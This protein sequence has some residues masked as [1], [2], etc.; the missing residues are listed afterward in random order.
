MKL[1][2]VCSTLS[3]AISLCV[4]GHAFSGTTTTQDFSK[5][6]NPMIG[7]DSHGNFSH[8]NKLPYV[9]TP[10]PM[11]LLSP[12]MNTGSWYYAYSSCTKQEPNCVDDTIVNPITGFRFSHEPSPWIGDYGYFSLMPIPASSKVGEDTYPSND[13]VAAYGSFEHANEFSHPYEYQI[14]FAN[15]LKSQM[16]SSRRAG[17]LRFTMPDPGQKIRLIFDLQDAG[18]Q[19]QDQISWPSNLSDFFGY[20]QDGN[21]EGLPSDFKA[22]FNM[23]FYQ[24]D[25]TREIHPTEIKVWDSGT[26]VEP[27]FNSKDQSY[28]ATGNHL[29]VAFTFDT[30][31]VSALVGNSYISSSQAKFNLEHEMGKTEGDSWQP[32]RF[33]DQVALSKADWNRYLSRVQLESP[34]V[35]QA[36]FDQERAVYYTGLYRTLI[37]PHAWFECSQY[38]ANGQCDTSASKNAD[39]SYTYNYLFHRSPYQAYQDD[40]AGQPLVHNGYIFTDEGTWDVYRTKYPFYSLVFPD[41]ENKLIQGQLNVYREGGWL[42]QWSSPGYRNSMTGTHS[43]CVIADAYLR[44][45]RDYD[46]STAFA[47][48]LKDAQQDPAGDAQCANGSKCG[49]TDFET[50]QAHGYIP[51]SSSGSE[52]TG[53][54]L[55]YAYDDVCIANMADGLIRE[56]HGLAKN[57]YRQLA[58]QMRDESSRITG[59]LFDADNPYKVTDP[60]G[61]T[62]TLRGFFHTREGSSQDG[63]PIWYGLTTSNPNLSGL[64]VW[65][66]GYNE[67]SAWQF[68]FYMPYDVPKLA[69]LFA[70]ANGISDP[71]AAL[72]AQL[73][74][75]FTSTSDYDAT[76]YGYIHEAKEMTYLG[77]GQYGFND[78]PSWGNEYQYNYTHAPGKP[79]ALSGI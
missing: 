62:D 4:S 58:K 42:S 8:G 29:I 72:E 21:Q 61:S 11:T 38:T 73:D 39:G 20:T 56:S 79:S 1:K 77:L 31:E 50:L 68:M 48:I 60:D 23:R 35:S 57:S 19:R 49:R 78:Q 34:N 12:Q 16:T 6:V 25:S 65:R 15:G 67:G 54:S 28:Q 63:Q 10:M 47:A 18:S 24:G 64:Y 27:E 40:A 59:N 66:N 30:N 52:A 37:N 43:D 70:K 69:T 71:K 53:N 74:K 5:Y 51:G 36:T 3:I 44:G 13:N 33:S 45:V 41:V 17:Y 7:T 26:S 76:A 32:H 9:A 46:V 22:F 75:L 2:K 55:D 14:T